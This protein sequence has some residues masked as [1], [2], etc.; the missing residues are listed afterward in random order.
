MRSLA[1]LQKNAPQKAPAAQRTARVVKFP[2][3]SKGRRLRSC[4][5]LAR[6][7]GSSRVEATLALPAP[8]QQQLHL[9]SV[10]SPNPAHPN[11]RH[12]TLTLLQSP[13]LRLQLPLLPSPN[14][15]LHQPL[16]RTPPRT[17]QLHP[18]PQQAPP[19]HP[20]QTGIHQPP[21][22]QPGPREARTAGLNQ[23]RAWQT[24]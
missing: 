3:F 19:Q 16:L 17:P 5:N 23:R 15:R 13:K 8:Q 4:G 1:Q 6:N 11:S 20:F 12:Q 9:P 24:K 10:R 18:V 14:L 21:R 2:L 7:S 22:S